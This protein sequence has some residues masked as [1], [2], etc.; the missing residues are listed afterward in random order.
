MS[1]KN[2]QWRLRAIAAV[3]APSTCSLAIEA[4]DALQLDSRK[5]S[6]P[7]RH[8]DAA[9]LVLAQSSQR[10]RQHRTALV[11]LCACGF[12][13]VACVHVQRRG[14]ERVCAR[15]RVCPYVCA[16]ACVC[17]HVCVCVCVCV[18]AC[19]CAKL[20]VKEWLCRLCVLHFQCGL[21]AGDA[22]GTARWQIEKL[23]AP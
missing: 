22:L 20:C 19:V 5:G 11:I 9:L 7:A 10:S 1:L 12:A 8:V 3:I 13:L 16:C 6:V 23:A 14:R 18:C 15:V 2:S 17:L 21:A 4:L